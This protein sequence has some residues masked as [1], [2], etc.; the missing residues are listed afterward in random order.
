[1][2]RLL[3]AIVEGYLVALEGKAL[4]AHATDFRHELACWLIDRAPRLVVITQGV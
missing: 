2:V 1:M 3:E 4:A